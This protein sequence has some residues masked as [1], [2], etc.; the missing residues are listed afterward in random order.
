[1]LRRDVFNIY[2][3]VLC[4]DACMSSCLKTTF[5]SQDCFPIN[6]LVKVWSFG[7]KFPNVCST[8]GILHGLRNFSN[9]VFGFRF[10]STMMAVVRIVLSSVFYGFSDFAK[11][12]HPAVLLK[13]A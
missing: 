8:F 10:S 12:L 5:V 3:N 11:E 9:F 1:M 4:D 2:L 13:P 6:W 7:V